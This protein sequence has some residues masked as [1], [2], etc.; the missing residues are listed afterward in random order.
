MSPNPVLNGTC[1]GLNG[2][3]VIGGMGLVAD[4]LRARCGDLHDRFRNG[5][6]VRRQ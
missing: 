3:P 5:Q 4:I 1:G 6:F 2:T